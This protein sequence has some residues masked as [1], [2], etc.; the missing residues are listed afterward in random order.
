[1]ID[2]V[3]VDPDL[4]FIAEA[5]N[6]HPVPFSG[7]ILGAVGE[8]L[9]AAQFVSVNTPIFLGTP[10]FFHI[11]HLDVKADA[12]EIACVPVLHLHLQGLGKHFIKGAGR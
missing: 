4:D 12:L 9:N 7:F 2:E 8:V 1:M 3:V 6:D 11:R 5:F 10:P